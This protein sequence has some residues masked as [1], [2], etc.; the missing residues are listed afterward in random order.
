M[1]Y[2]YSDQSGNYASTCKTIV[3]W[4]CVFIKVRDISIEMID[5]KYEHR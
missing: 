2:L 5:Q 1:T 4:L 3:E